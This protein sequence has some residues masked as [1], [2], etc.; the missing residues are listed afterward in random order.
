MI[1]V[2]ISLHLQRIHLNTNRLFS[3]NPFNP[4]SQFPLGTMSKVFFRL[5]CP[6]C[7]A[8]SARII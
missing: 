4:T 3:S 7:S 1:D 5:T 6:A 8:L 2:L